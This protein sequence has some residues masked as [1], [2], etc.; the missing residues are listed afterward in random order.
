MMELKNC[1]IESIE[2]KQEET[3]LY[4]E[5]YAA[6]YGNIDSYNDIVQR[7]AFDNYLNTPDVK[8][9]KFC[10]N[11]NIN[12]V[13]GVIEDIKA[14]EKGLWFRAKVSNT[15][16]GRD[17]AE[18]I[19]D[20]ALSEFS[21]GYKTVKSNYKD[22]GVRVLTELYLYEISVVSRAANP[23]A[24]VTETERKDEDMEDK[25]LSLQEMDYTQLKAELEEI[26]SRKAEVL[27]EIDA[28]I[29]N[30]INLKF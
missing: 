22:D 27:A 21:I 23:Q 7:G 3:H 30:A 6:I 19:A 12:E 13:I 28:R 26:E 1:A 2:V 17:V 29:I 9:C 15:T 24:V 11:H 8:R 10:F 16:L 18:L 5:G 20:K 25:E 14:D 4:V